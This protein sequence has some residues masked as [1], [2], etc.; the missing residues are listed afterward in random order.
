MPTNSS[1]DPSVQ[2]V[3][4]VPR[5]AFVKRDAEGRIDLVSPIPAPF[6]Y[7]RVTGV[8]GGD[9][10]PQDAIVLGPRLPRGHTVRLRVHGVVRFI[11][12]GER[13]DKWVCG[14]EPPSRL[15]LRAV[16][17]F[18]HVYARVKRIRDRLLMKQG[19]S[20]FE[21]WHPVSMPPT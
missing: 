7:G 8:L 16:V 12:R 21:G 14:T 15:Q 3:I 10:E 20:A 5:G 13:D 4:E 6:N 19:D 17:G 18:F 9:G 11:D 2:V 1:S